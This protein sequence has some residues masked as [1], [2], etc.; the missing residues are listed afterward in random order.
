[1]QDYRRFRGRGITRGR[2]SFS[3]RFH[4]IVPA[5]IRQHSRWQGGCCR[6][7]P[8]RRSRSTCG[9]TVKVFDDSSPLP[10][11]GRHARTLSHIPCRSIVLCIRSCVTGR[12]TPHSCACAIRPAAQTACALRCSGMFFLDGPPSAASRARVPRPAAPAH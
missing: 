11:P 4:I 2:I 5:F 7:P 10:M 8:T 12:V 3:E 6:G 9:M 1:M